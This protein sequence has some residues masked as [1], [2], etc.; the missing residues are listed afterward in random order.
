MENNNSF[1]IVREFIE[2]PIKDIM[3]LYIQYVREGA[4]SKEKAKNGIEVYGFLSCMFEHGMPKEASELFGGY[5][6]KVVDWAKSV[7]DDLEIGEEHD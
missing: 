7:I 4:I 3:E 6:R 5:R 2:N 1:E